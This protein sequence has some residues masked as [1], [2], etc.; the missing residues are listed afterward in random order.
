MAIKKE[1]KYPLTKTWGAIEKLRA[2][3]E[4]YYV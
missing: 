2:Q 4:D 3:Y 1:I